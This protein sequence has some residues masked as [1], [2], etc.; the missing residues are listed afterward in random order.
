[1]QIAEDIGVLFICD[2]D[3]DEKFFLSCYIIF[4]TKK[5]DECPKKRDP[6]LWLTWDKLKKSCLDRYFLFVNVFLISNYECIKV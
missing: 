6:K 2:G 1:M 3:L 4:I 5:C